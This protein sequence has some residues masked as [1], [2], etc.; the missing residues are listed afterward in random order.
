MKAINET[1][2]F[3]SKRDTELISKGMY[4]YCEAC[5]SSQ[6]VETQ[7]PDPR[8]CQGCFDF[9]MGEVRLLGKVR[10]KANPP[11]WFPR[12]RLNQNLAPE[13]KWDIPCKGGNNMS[14]LKGK[15]S[16]VD[17][18]QPR[19]PKKA[20]G[21]RGRKSLELP[22]EKI[23]EWVNEGL[24]AKAITTRLKKLG[25]HVSYKTIQRR[26]RKKRIPGERSSVKQHIKKGKERRIE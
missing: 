6:P 4:F 20:S 14:T 10:C 2:A 22:D 8:Y 21:K 26:I 17:L 1:I 19:P 9:L 12:P 24:G 13:K 3:D 5:L 18:I 23:R 7:S 16:R 25:I 11:D 15:K